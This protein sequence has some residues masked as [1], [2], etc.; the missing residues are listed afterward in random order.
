MIKGCVKATHTMEE[1]YASLM[2]EY[3][4]LD[5][6]R[7][8]CNA[9]NDIIAEQKIAPSI[10]ISP[11]TTETGSYTIEFHDDYDKKSGPFFE[12]LLKILEIDRC[13]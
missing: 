3:S 5:A 7:T 1:R 4:N 2:I 6:K 12:K 10:I 8:I 11:K 13:E 9:I